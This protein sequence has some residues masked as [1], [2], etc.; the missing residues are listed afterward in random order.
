MADS[1]FKSPVVH[2]KSRW[3]SLLHDSIQGIGDCMA[4]LELDESFS[5]TLES[6]DI[7]SDLSAEL[8]CYSDE[9]VMTNDNSEIDHVI[10][11]VVSDLLFSQSRVSGSSTTPQKP[12]PSE[13]RPCYGQESSPII[14]ESSTTDVSSESEV[15]CGSTE[16]RQKNKSI[17]AKLRHFCK[18]MKH[19]TS[20]KSK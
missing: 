3:R 17:L 8:S 9:F 4:E 2:S 10:T 12:T 16:H 13:R 15:T 14:Y 5:R 18:Q 7:S 1:F 19:K 6:W 11:S 20:K